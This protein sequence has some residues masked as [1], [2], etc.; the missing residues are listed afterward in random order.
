MNL[1]ILYQDEYLVAIQKP[2][3]LFVHRT[4]MGKDDEIF[5]L[6]LLRDQIGK[7]VNPIHRIDRK[8][9]GIVLFSMDME[10]HKA[11]GIQFED[12]LIEKEYTALVRGYTEDFGTIDYPL[13][14]LSGKVQEAVT[15]YETIE[16]MEVNVPFGKFKT[17]RYSIVKVFPKTGRYHQIRKHFAHIFH[18]IIGDR[19]H[20]CNK[21]NKLFLEKWNMNDMMLCATK[22][23][24]FHPVLETNINIE[25][26]LSKEFLQC[27]KNLNLS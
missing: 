10:V 2:H 5:A 7:K 21:Q 23:T 24:F 12:N 19:P 3:N 27:L 16:R 18:P 26:P 13:T 20:G 22:L 4:S 15:E 25:S 9:S 6:Q 11:I 14:N 8:T 17:S 1:P